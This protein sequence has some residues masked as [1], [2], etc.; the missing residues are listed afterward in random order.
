VPSSRARAQPPRPT[1]APPAR[2]DPSSA[3]PGPDRNIV[4]AGRDALEW[5]HAPAITISKPSAICTPQSATPPAHHNQHPPMHTNLRQGGLAAGAMVGA[6]A[7]HLGELIVHLG[8][9][10]GSS[11]VIKGH[12]G[13]SSVIKGHQG[14]SESP[15]SAH[16][17]S[18]PRR[19]LRPR[20]RVVGPPVAP[21]TPGAPSG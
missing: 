19:Q 12:Q 20:E 13:S 10:Q 6:D 1:S 2:S 11:R 14:S 5:M 9:N 21:P 3:A 16:R 4:R 8:R 15:R 7:S 18:Y 17:P